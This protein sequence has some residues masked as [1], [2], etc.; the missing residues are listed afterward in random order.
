MGTGDWLA[1]EPNEHSILLE[2]VDQG[3]IVRAEETFPWMLLHWAGF[4]SAD[5]RL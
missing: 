3:E 5:S 4:L 1:S 2:N